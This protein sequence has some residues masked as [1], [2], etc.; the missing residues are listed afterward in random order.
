MQKLG[1]NDLCH[2]GSGNKYKKCCLAKDEAGNITRI[3]ASPEPFSN[4]IN[5]NTLIEKT[6]SWKNELYKLE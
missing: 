4:P 6:L 3:A 1:R 5:L 2:C